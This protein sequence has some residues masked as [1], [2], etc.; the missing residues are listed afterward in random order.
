MMYYAE[1]RFLDYHCTHGYH[2]RHGGCCVYQASEDR[3]TSPAE[4]G[5]EIWSP[6]V[7]SRMDDGMA[8]FGYRFPCTRYCIFVY[9][10]FFLLPISTLCEN[11]YGGAAEDSGTQRSGEL[12]MADKG[13]R[14]VAFVLEIFF[15]GVF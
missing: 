8:V 4:S 7:D 13:R 12:F 2:E 15:T 10:K 6:W 9:D 14:R 5:S 11:L 1:Q 3:N